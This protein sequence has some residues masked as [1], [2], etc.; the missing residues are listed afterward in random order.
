M[1]DSIRNMQKVI[2]EKFGRRVSYPKA[3]RVVDWKN[4]N[5]TI[6]LNSDTLNKILLGDKY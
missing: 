3:S 1:D 6:T 2:L 5:S 4:R